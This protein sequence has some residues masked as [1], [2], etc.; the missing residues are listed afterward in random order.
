LLPD[1]THVDDI[2]CHRRNFGS[3]EQPVV[4]KD[5]QSWAPRGHRATGQHCPFREQQAHRSVGND[6]MDIRLPGMDVKTLL[7]EGLRLGGGN[8]VETK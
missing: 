6:N 1:D 5:A 3:R 4:R 8:G 7:V 2:G